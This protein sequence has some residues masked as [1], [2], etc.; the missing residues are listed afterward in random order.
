LYNKTFG[1]QLLKDK[2]NCLFWKESLRV[3]NHIRD[4]NVDLGTIFSRNDKLRFLLPVRNPL[5]CA[6]SNLKRGHVRH[7][8]NLNRESSM[9]EVTTEI[10]R[11][12]LW[13]LRLK[14]KY[15]TRFFFFFEHDFGTDTLRDMAGFL[16]IEPDEQWCKNSL[17][18]FEVKSSYEHSE[19]LRDFYNNLVRERFSSYPE[20][21]EK[22]LHFTREREQQ[23]C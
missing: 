20:F 12:F 7:F 23:E 3:S 18:V 2:V 6:M 19:D 21:S 15:P 16:G 22:L 14:E 13:F 1:N 4:N 5:D 17:A 9:E 8:T 11:E 10:L